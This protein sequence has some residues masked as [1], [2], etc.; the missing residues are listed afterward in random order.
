MANSNPVKEFWSQQA[1]KHGASALAT[2]PDR[3]YRQLE[4]REIIH[5]LPD[6]EIDV[7]DVGC[8]N[9]FSTH[10]FA[11]ARPRASFVGI[12]F[13]PEMIEIANAEFYKENIHFHEGNVESLSTMHC[14]CYDY[15]ISERCLINLPD[16]ERQKNAILQLKSCLA[17]GGTLILVENCVDGLDNLNEMRATVDLPPIQQRWH[18]HYMSFGPLLNFLWKSFNDGSVEWSNIGSLYYVI[19]RVV[20]AKVA[21]MEGQE[22]EY[23][24]PINEVASNLPPIDHDFSPNYMFVCKL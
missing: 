7:L 10:K 11:Q 1:T 21:E 14:G 9:G 18:N 20:H 8:G 4:I 13:S 12:D 2:S 15:V 5:Q 23:D 16:W 6:D 19:S 17:P 22:P 24:H 3:H